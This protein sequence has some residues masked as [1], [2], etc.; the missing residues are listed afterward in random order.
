MESKADKLDLEEA[1]KAVFDRHLKL[2]KTFEKIEWER[3]P[4]GKNLPPDYSLITED[5]TYAVE[6]T[7]LIRIKK[8]KDDQCEVGTYQATRLKLADELTKEALALGILQGTYTINFVMDW[9]VELKKARNQI[10]RQVFDYLEK[11]KDD[12]GSYIRYQRKYTRRS[13]MLIGQ[14]HRRFS[15]AR[16]IWSRGQLHRS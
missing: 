9:L 8:S 7:G 11:S 3:Y 2:C 13:L 1:C 16:S 4:N 12:R 6:I 10:R 14:I 5:K 15:Q